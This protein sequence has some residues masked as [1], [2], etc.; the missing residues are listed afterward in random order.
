MNSGVWL[1]F[2][3][4]F[5]SWIS[6]LGGASCTAPGASALS[7]LL[8]RE[9]VAMPLRW[10]QS[11]ESGA[12]APN[13]KHSHSGSFPQIGT[14]RMSP[15]PP[16]KTARYNRH[17]G[18]KWKNHLLDKSGP[19]SLCHT[20][21]QTHTHTHTQRTHTHTLQ[22]INKRKPLDPIVSWTLL[23]S[24]SMMTAPFSQWSHAFQH[25]VFIAPER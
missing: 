9:L 19:Y 6:L 7:P 12:R 1:S 10:V 8:D 3:Q 2:T 11:P 25:W 17:P 15:E 24:T 22:G 20:Q 16:T 14:C 5:C 4:L 18:T 21:T 23:H 13:L